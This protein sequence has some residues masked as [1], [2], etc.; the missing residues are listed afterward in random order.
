MLARRYPPGVRRHGAGLQ[1]CVKVR[2]E[3]RFQAFPLDT[4]ERE[5]TGWQEDERAKLRL[6]LPKTQAGTFAADAERYLRLPD[7]QKMPDY[8]QREQHIRE[9]IIYFGGT[10]RRRTIT[11][12]AIATRRDA[13]LED[14]YAAHSVNLRLR[15]L[16][17]VW[18]RLDARHAPNPARMVP[19]VEEPDPVARG[20]PYDVVE[21]ILHAMPETAIGVR[22]DGTRTA[23]KPRVNRAKVRLRVIA[24]TGL[25]HSQLKRLQPA[26][27]DEDAGTMR[28]TA[29]KKGKK[30]RRALD[31]PL[32]E[33]LPLL[34]QAVDAFRQ[35]RALNLWG[36]FSNSTVH[37]SF[38]AACKTLK[39]TGLRPS[40]FR[41]SMGTAVY[42]ETRDLRVTGKLL[43]HR[44]Q[45]TT[46]RYTI[47]AVAP[48]IQAAIDAVRERLAS[49]LA[50][51]TPE[52]CG[53]RR[54]SADA[55]T[56]SRAKSDRTLDRK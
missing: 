16:S 15:A 6:T 56:G 9:W 10:I 51:T 32:P 31:K 40:D 25:S 21:A 43:G 11:E 29:R 19:E 50:S 34:P 28:L 37:R 47:A 1:A 7:V 33:L 39:L 44:S 49:T 23:G 13:L 35:F 2:G 24:Y 54:K 12:P 5:I 22:N 36:N 52:P 30:I 45:R 41:H 26:D 38:M 3:R 46:E 27:V 53:N 8:Q 42:A 48:Q 55:T 4:P 18:T 20:L 14:G 17:N